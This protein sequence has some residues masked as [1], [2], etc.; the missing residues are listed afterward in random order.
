[1]LIWLIFTIMGLKSTIRT[2]P[3][4]MLAALAVDLFLF[5]PISI[6]EF[7]L[8]CKVTKLRWEE[9]S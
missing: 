2:Q 1:M 5:L 8:H 4:K 9:D 7:F 6:R 3:K